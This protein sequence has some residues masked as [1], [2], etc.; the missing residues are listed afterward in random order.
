[1]IEASRFSSTDRIRFKGRETYGRWPSYSF[2]K[3][4]PPDNLIRTF[5]VTSA[6]EGR[7]DLIAYQ[8]YGISTLDWVLIAFNKVIE[9]LNWPSAGTTIEYPLESIVVPEVVR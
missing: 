6:V 5:R 9:P 3:Q 7:P 8:V 4:R 1:M 2:L